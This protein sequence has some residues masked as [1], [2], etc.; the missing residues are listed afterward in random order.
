MPEIRLAKTAGFCYGVRNAV[1]IAEKTAREAQKTVYTYGPLIHN[2]SVVEHLQK[3]GIYSVDSLDALSEGD[4]VIIRAHGVG[5]AAYREMEARG[6]NV[7][8]GTCPRVQM[9]HRIVEEQE[10]AG[11]RILIFGDSAHPEVQGIAGW[12][13]APLCASC[14]GK[15][16]FRG[17][18][19]GR[20]SAGPGGSCCFSGTNNI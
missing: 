1:E 15:D 3:M 8:D 5:R 19:T 18:R 6:L 12:W 4:T 11:Q 20:F 16:R 9:I 13:E 10:Q 2:Q 17:S 14:S 7:V